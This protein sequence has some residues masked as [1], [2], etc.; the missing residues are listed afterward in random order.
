MFGLNKYIGKSVTTKNLR[1]G[2][3]RYHVIAYSQ[4]LGYKLY[5]PNTNTTVNINK[6]SFLRQYKVEKK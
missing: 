6:E 5:E 3:L 4:L 1:G 2:Y